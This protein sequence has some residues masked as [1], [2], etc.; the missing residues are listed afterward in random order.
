MFF[1]NMISMEEVGST[2]TRIINM[3]VRLSA[4]TVRY[5]AIS[6]IKAFVGAISN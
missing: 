2:W 5:V 6:E 3:V 4:R 1:N